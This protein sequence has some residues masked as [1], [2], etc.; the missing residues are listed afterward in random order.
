MK[1]VINQS[2][3]ATVKV[4][5]FSEKSSGTGFFIAPNLIATNMHVVSMRNGTGLTISTGI[6]VTTLDGEILEASVVS[7][8]SKTEPDPMSYDFAI[9]KTKSVPKNNPRFL[10]LSKQK[11]GSDLVGDEIIFSGHP[12]GTPILLTHKGMISGNAPGLIALQASVNRGNSG[13]AL[14]NS[15]GEVIG[16]ITLREGD[17]TAR[18]DGIHKQISANSSSIGREVQPGVFI[19]SNPTFNG[20]SPLD[21]I[22]ELTET[23]RNYISPGIGYAYEISFLR[24]YLSRHPE[25][26]VAL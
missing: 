12:F 3:S 1:N 24:T 23:L 9:L 21:A 5:S 7:I 17:I 26:G 4:L 15:L 19:K 8:P 18:L 13:G 16:I 25:F 6:T 22:G 2:R 14:C 11:K 20:I 10:V